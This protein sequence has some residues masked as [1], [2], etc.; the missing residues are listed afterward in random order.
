[1]SFF[2][3][4]SK[5]QKNNETIEQVAKSEDVIID[6]EDS[7]EL[8]SSEEGG[9]AATEEMEEVNDENEITVDSTESSDV[10]DVEIPNENVRKE[11]RTIRID[12]ITYDITDFDH[13]GGNIINYASG[14][15]D[16]TDTF[17]EFHYRSKHARRVLQSLPHVDDNNVNISTEYSEI[18][19]DFREMR[20]TL[21][22]NGCF[23]PDYIHV[24]FRLME[25]AFY[26]GLGTFLASYNTYASLFSFIL[27][28][29]RC[30][31]VQHEAGHTSLT[32]NKSIDR[33]IQTI[34]MGFGGGVSSSVWNSMHNK[35]HATPQKIK[36]DIDLD[37]TPAVAFFKTAFEK[38]TNGPKSAKYM[39]R[40]WTR[41]Q[42]WSFLP[43]VNG[44]FVHLFWTY[45]LHP[46]KVLG[47]GLSSAT[48]ISQERM[49]KYKKQ[50]MNVKWLE[51]ICMT[52]SHTVI[53]GIFM[54]YTGYSIFTAYFLLMICNFWNFIYLFG[55]FSLSHT[56]TDVIPEDKHLLW[57][58]YAIGHSV[59]ISTKS[60][61]VTWAMGYLNFQIEHHLF[62]SMPQYKNAV[63]APYIRRFCD[64]WNSDKHHLKYT[65]MSYFKAWKMMFT[66]LN[67]VG[68]HYYDNGVMVEDK[69]NN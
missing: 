65:E 43:L 41:L 59:N 64:K 48:P 67:E 61:L 60:S 38:N 52:L 33:V 63:A 56:F 27:F 19:E 40:L 15:N 9:A 2:T 22:N 34:T 6:K 26:F 1:M 13:P 18:K 69:K 36:H 16:A 10:D 8:E 35:H 37:T 50:I 4:K 23:E 7:E 11:K 47:I 55:H 39:N 31:W 17:R 3:S 28:K 46:R 25:I 42:A 44:V 5:S 29:T 32:G 57:F 58:E 62:P 21:I 12:G 54:S 68:K 66:N 20:T 14:D 51:F 24:Y 30:G 49:S 53:P 45:Y